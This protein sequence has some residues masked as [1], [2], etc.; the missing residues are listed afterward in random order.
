[1]SITT[2]CTNPFKSYCAIV[3]DHFIVHSHH[4]IASL[5]HRT[6]AEQRKDLGHKHT[7]LI[8]RQLKVVA[9]VLTFN[10]LP[11]DSQATKTIV[12]VTLFNVFQEMFNN[13]HLLRRSHFRVRYLVR[14]IVSTHISLYFAHHH[15]QVFR[16]LTH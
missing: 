12:H 1:M 2:V 4:N 15:D 7:S 6:A 9:H 10:R 3:S 16:L 13:S 8:T 11:F 5:E 14:Y